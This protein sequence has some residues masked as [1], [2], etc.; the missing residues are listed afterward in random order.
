MIVAM[1]PDRPARSASRRERGFT[2]VELLVGLTLF[3]LL[4]VLLFGG[5]RFGLRAWESGGDRIDRT[6]RVELAQSLLRRELNQ[7]RLPKLAAA[8]QDRGTLSA[9][10]GTRNAVTFIAPLPTHSGAGGL[11]VVSLTEQRAGQHT[12]LSLAWQLFRPDEIGTQPFQADDEAAVIEDIASLQFAYYG[13]SDRDQP[14]A[15]LD[16]WI[17]QRTLPQLIRVRVGFPVGDPRRWT[18]L[19]IAP[20]LFTP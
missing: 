9:F 10:T 18:D 16:R 11:Y 17:G 19:V 13:R 12:Y 1:P 15:W 3:S 6:Q 2:L 7:A 5:F 8:A 4:S 14:P 20:R